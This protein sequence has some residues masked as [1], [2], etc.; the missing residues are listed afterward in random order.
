MERTNI[1]NMPSAT[2]QP[3]PTIVV[4]DLSFISLSQVL[5]ALIA[6]AAEA[7]DFLLMVKPQFEVGKDSL[8]A[9]GVVRDPGLRKEA[10]RKVIE[11]GAQL[12]LGCDGVVASA[13]PGPKG[14]VEYF[15]W[16]KIGGATISDADIESAIAKGPQS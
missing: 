16:L 15:V 7:A 4:A 14:N 3:V 6:N 5:P 9:G 12:G 8:G 10:I 1:R 13:L 11:S 2:L